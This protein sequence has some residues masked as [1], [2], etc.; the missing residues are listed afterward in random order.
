M[1]YVAPSAEVRE[2]FHRGEHRRAYEMLGAHPVEQDG[3]PMWHFAVWAPNA[4]AV[5]LVGEF[6]HWDKAAC[7]RKRS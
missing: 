6:C 5:S 3:K 7:L 2:W 1:R 4:Q